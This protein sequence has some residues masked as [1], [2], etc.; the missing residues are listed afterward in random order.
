MNAKKHPWEMVYQ[1]EGRLYKEPFPRF[2]EVVQEFKDRGCTRILDLGCGNGR[3]LVHLVQEGFQVCGLDISS[4]ALR[5]TRGWLSDRELQSDT[6]LGDMRFPLPFS[7]SCFSAVLSTQVIHHARKAEVRQSITEIFR[8]LTMGGVAFITVSGQK[9][10][11]EDFIQVEPAT[12]VPL[13]GAEKG[14]PHHIFTREEVEFEFRRF[15]VER[16]T[17]RAGGK[18]IAALVS[19]PYEGA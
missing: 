5:L 15:R 9:D 18:V 11:G 16:V 1:R 19:K 7:D 12:F 8:V 3:H 2:E 14:V 17:E 10:E 6:V 4:T 13:T